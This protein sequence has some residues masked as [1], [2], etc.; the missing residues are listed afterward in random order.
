MGLPGWLLRAV[1]RKGFRLPTPVQRRAIPPALSGGDVVAMARTGSGKTAAFLLP[2]LARLGQDHAP[3]GPR[4]LVLSPTRELTLQ[5]HKARGPSLLLVAF[6][7]PF[8]YAPP[9]HT[10]TYSCTYTYAYT[11][12]STYIYAYTHSSTGAA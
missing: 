5:S 1:R 7:R 10:Y 3:G 8:L 4:G 11:Y 2:L 9:V 12:P 6:S